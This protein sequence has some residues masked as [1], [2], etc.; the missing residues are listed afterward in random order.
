M[1]WQSP[2]LIRPGHG[3]IQKP[4]IERQC[5]AVGGD[6]IVH[7]FIKSAIVSETIHSASLIGHTGL[8][9]VGE[10]DVVHAVDD[11]IVDSLE[12]FKIVSCEQG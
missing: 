1:Q 7:Q 11:Y 9:L 12:T 6:A 4:L 10:E 8:P 5:K 2:H 3:H